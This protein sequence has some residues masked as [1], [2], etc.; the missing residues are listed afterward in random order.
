MSSGGG[1]GGGSSSGS[2]GG[3]G[4]GMSGGDYGTPSA[5][6]YKFSYKVSTKKCSLIDKKIIFKKIIFVSNRSMMDMEI[7]ITIWRML[8]NQEPK[9]VVTDTPTLLEYIVKVSSIRF[10]VVFSKL[11]FKKLLSLIMNS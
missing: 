8:M 10:P 6:P 5:E 4:G 7:L 9:R 3:Y 11:D 1:Y 2:N